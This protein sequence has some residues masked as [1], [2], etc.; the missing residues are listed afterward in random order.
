MFLLL[1]LLM[2]SPAGCYVTPCFV[3]NVPAESGVN[4]FP[5]RIYGAALARFMDA[6]IYCLCGAPATV[7]SVNYPA[8]CNKKRQRDCAKVQRQVQFALKQTDK[9]K[10]EFV[11]YEK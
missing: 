7:G 5:P 4:I 11:K 10:L 1:M 6:P 9:P 8:T 2:F 3:I